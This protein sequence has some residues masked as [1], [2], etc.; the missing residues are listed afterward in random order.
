MIITKCPTCNDAWTIFKDPKTKLNHIRKCALQKSYSNAEV[1]KLV[2]DQV[3]ELYHKAEEK[4]RIHHDNRTLLEGVISRKGKEVQVVG[5]EKKKKPQGKQNELISN[6]Y[7]RDNSEAPHMDEEEKEVTREVVLST[8]GGSTYSQATSTQ[9]YKELTKRIKTNQ[10]IERGDFLNVAT[11]ARS[12]IVEAGTRS[13]SDSV[14]SDDASAK[15]SVLAEAAAKARRKKGT[16][17]ANGVGSK[18][19]LKAAQLLKAKEKDAMEVE[20]LEASSLL[21]T[22][23]IGA[24]IASTLASNTSSSFGTAAKGKQQASSAN[25]SKTR[26]EPYSDSRFR[27][28]EKVKDIAALRT[29]KTDSSA[30]SDIESVN[31]ATRQDTGSNDEYSGMERPYRNPSDLSLSL[32]DKAIQRGSEKR[33]QGYD[34]WALA[35]TAEDTVRD[36]YVV[37][38]PID[39]VKYNDDR[40][41]EHADSDF[42]SHN[43]HPLHRLLMTML[44]SPLRTHSFLI[45]MMIFIIPNTLLHHLRNLTINLIQLLRTLAIILPRRHHPRHRSPNCPYPR[46]RLH[47]FGNHLQLL[48][49]RTILTLLILLGQI[50]RLNLCP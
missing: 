7:S 4:N 26:L 38:L 34:A 13:A 47:R 32:L 43:L 17:D 42:K 41:N 21:S 8:Q 24:S 19:W 37:S 33:K 10:R 2:E 28:A 45:M 6:A 12:A 46:E 1:N 30:E 11:S 20:D 16:A 29:R 40:E 15:P 23:H 48:L 50:Y 35:G 5:V 39:Y 36:R 3:R 14:A 25:T 22:A 44:E 49:P 31:A 27:L 9:V 18:N